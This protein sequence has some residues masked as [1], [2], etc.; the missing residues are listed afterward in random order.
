MSLAHRIASL[1]LL[2]AA[3]LSPALAQQ[4]CEPKTQWNQAAPG[5]PVVWNWTADGVAVWWWCPVTVNGAP[6]MR[7]GG[8]G[9]RWVDGWDAVRAAAPRVQAASAPFAAF[10]TELAAVEAKLPAVA[11]GSRDECTRRL[12]HHG[13]CVALRTTVFDPPFPAAVSVADALAPTRCGPAPNCDA[14]VPPGPVW[15]T[16]AG[17]SSIFPVT[18]GSLGVPIAGRRAP[19]SALCDLSRL[20]IVRGSFTYGA[21]AAGPA[22]E[23]VVCVQ[24]PA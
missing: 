7:A 1:A 10:R 14:I 16:P 19:G 5:S 8:Y 6:K 2:L 24:V 9:G 17:G 13:A 20:R 18:A 3:A 23:A 11:A 22:T 4:E 12:I 21:L 15:R